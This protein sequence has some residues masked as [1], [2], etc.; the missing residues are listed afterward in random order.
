M[1]PWTLTN[2]AY[3]EPELFQEFRN[4]SKIT[5]PEITDPLFIKHI[6]DFMEHQNWSWF[7]SKQKENYVMTID[8]NSEHEE[9]VAVHTNLNSAVFLCCIDALFSLKDQ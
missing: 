8:F 5:L 6:F 1:N 2:T 3:I 7:L 9:S 4:L